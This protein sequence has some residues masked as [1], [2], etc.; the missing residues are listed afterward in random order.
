MG[1]RIHSAII[2]LSD[3]N[4]NGITQVL[5][6]VPNG[7]ICGIVCCGTSEDLEYH[8]LL[9]IVKS[10]IYNT[11][12]YCVPIT[13]IPQ[14]I[15]P[16]GGLSIDIYTL[17]EPENILIKEQGGICFGV[18]E[19]SQESMLFVEGIPATDF[20][21]NV[22]EQ[23]RELFGRLE[24]LLSEHGFS[25]DDIVRQWNYIGNIVAHRDGKQN[26]Q[27]FNDARTEFYNTGSWHNGYPAATGIG[28]EGEGIIVGVIAYKRAGH[29]YPIDNPLQV[30]AHAY[31]KQV[32]IDEEANAPKST[33]KF[34]RAKVIE[35]E[36]GT[37][38]FVS[39][40]AAIRGEKSVEAHSAGVQTIQTLENIEQLV[41]PDNLVR[42]GCKPYELEYAK[43]HV[44]IKEAKDYEE[45]QSVVEQRWP[46]VSALYSVADVCRSELLVEIE[47]I[48]TTKI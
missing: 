4:F 43:I 11:L 13:L 41:S 29:I 5:E 42:C 7:R 26:Y 30:A 18:I 17:D 38:C 44:Y 16:K 33:P 10:E 21:A 9:S 1:L 14:P 2:D 15:L 28:S 27:E 12:Q 47:G 35:T 8:D 37:Y 46:N 39:G 22:K 19:S 31:S 20:S 6:C 40:T 32:L 25:V 48:L 23:S 3:A 45:V 36:R 34:E 24:S